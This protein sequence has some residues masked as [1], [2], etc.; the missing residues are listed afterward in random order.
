MQKQSFLPFEK[1][2]MLRCYSISLQ[3]PFFQWKGRKIYTWPNSA[4]IP[5]SHNWWRNTKFDMELF[6]TYGRVTLVSRI[7]EL[8]LVLD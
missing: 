1:C 8:F 5:F 2:E 4:Y 3:K 7:C 6:Y